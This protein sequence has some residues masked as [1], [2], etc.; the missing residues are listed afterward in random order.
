MRT[1]RNENPFLAKLKELLCKN[2]GEEEWLDRLVDVSID[3]G[4]YQILSEEID[5]QL[6]RLHGVET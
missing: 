4:R 3:E 1:F 5:E 2:S 6:K